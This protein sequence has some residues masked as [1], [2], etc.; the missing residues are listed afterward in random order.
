MP[1]SKEG[2]ITMKTLSFSTQ[3]AGNRAKASDGTAAELPTGNW[4]EVQSGPLMVGGILIGVGAL[5]ALAGM[6]VA[7]THVGMATRAWLKD[8]ETPPDQLA[9]LK[10]EQAKTAWAA[11]ASSYR[12]HPNA[13]VRMVRRTSTAAR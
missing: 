13:Q 7:G 9:R 2:H 4:P 8:L 6:A 11:G 12:E 1:S 3:T 5:I 10:W